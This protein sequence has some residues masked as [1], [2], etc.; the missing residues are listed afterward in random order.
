MEDVLIYEFIYVYD[1]CRIKYDFNDVKMLVCIEV[2]FVVLLFYLLIII[3][4]DSLKFGLVM[5]LSLL[6]RF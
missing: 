6:E 4:R 1:N 3:G 5:V 2:F